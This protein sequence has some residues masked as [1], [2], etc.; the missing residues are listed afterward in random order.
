MRTGA[1]TWKQRFDTELT[2]VLKVQGS[3]AGEVAG[4]LGVALGGTDRDQLA[5]SPTENLAAYDLYLK[6]K[7][8]VSRDP[9]TQRQA[10]AFFEQA[11][12]LD[13]RFAEGWGALARVD[14]DRLRQRPARPDQRHPCPGGGR[15]RD[16]ARPRWR[17]RPGG[18]GRLPHAGHQR[19][20][21][22]ARP[23][24]DRD[25]PGAERRRGAAPRVA[26]RLGP[27]RHRGGA[28]LP[29]PGPQPRPALG[30]HRPGPPL[31]AGAARPVRRG[32]PGGRGGARA[33]PR[34][35]AERAVP[36]D[37]VC[38]AR[39]PR[40]CAARHPRG[41][42]ARGGAGARRPA[43]GILRD[44]LDP[45]AGGAPARLPPEPGRVRQRCR[46]VGPVA[47]HRVLG[48][49]GQGACPRLRRLGA[50]DDLPAAAGFSRQRPDQCPVRPH[51][52]LPRPP[53]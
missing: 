27:A 26:H 19:V 33:C 8:I 10:A 29:R 38:R 12:A 25:E 5:Q 20:G 44:D 1:A 14:G 52:R 22:G 50:G 2:D 36:R 21:A 4:A 6:G 17:R 30:Q 13:D 41:A 49:G 11:V 15:A 7:A 46:V 24:R 34:R 35:P 9:V 53:G 3:I 31:R 23:H 48:R 47:R 32:D 45:R 16:G 40:R 42:G 43:R 28:L 51:A 37:G 18:D 39:R